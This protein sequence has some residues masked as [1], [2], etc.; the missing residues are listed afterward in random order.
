MDV[1]DTDEAL[2]ANARHMAGFRNFIRPTPDNIANLGPYDFIIHAGAISD[3]RCDDVNA[4]VETN[5]ELTRKLVSLRKKSGANLVYFSSAS[6]YGDNPCNERHPRYQPQTPYAVSKFIAEKEVLGKDGCCVLRPFNVY[7][8]GE[9]SKKE[10][11]RSILYRIAHA[12]GTGTKMKVFSLD[13]LRDFVSVTD[14]AKS[15]VS[16]MEGA[17]DVSFTG[18]PFNIGRGSHVSVLQLC[19]TA[20]EAAGD[21]SWIETG[22]NPYKGSYQSV[23]CAVFDERPRMYDP[24]HFRN[25]LNDL[26][27][28]VKRFKLGSM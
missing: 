13:A 8:I 26:Q 6:V 5:Y 16:M 23:S 25:P 21:D 20:S 1:L 11:T 10:H 27:L 18:N 22:E 19:Q 4:L 17:R 24:K 7:G 3:S 28:M 9:F 14:V 15:V 12:A 2:F